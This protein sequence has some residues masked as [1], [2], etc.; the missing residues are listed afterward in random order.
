M[1]QQE[2]PPDASTLIYV[3]KANAFAEVSRCIRTILVT[4]SVWREA[5]DEGERIG[6]PEVGGIRNAAERGF[7]RL[8]ELS[9][10]ADWEA[11]RVRSVHR[12]GQG[13]S[14]VI[15]LA[16][17]GGFVIIDEGRASRVAR[18]LGYR[19]LSTLFLPVIGYRSA[20]LDQTEA[21]RLVRRLAVVANASA[22]AV[23]A[24]EEYIGGET[25]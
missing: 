12:L 16:A 11:E 25:Q 9:N 15:A 17:K 21:V 20:R 5:V 3:A 19:T 24:I 1:D 6:A 23:L 7:L 13:E 8:V 14:E 2:A 4:P 18:S 10:Q 22:E